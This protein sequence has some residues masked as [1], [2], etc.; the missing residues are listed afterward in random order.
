M[1]RKSKYHHFRR[2]RAQRYN[3]VAISRKKK[4]THS[5]LDVNRNPIFL[6][7]IF[8]ACLTI[9]FVLMPQVVIK[10]FLQVFFDLIIY[11]YLLIVNVLS[12]VRDEVSSQIASMTF[13]DL[14]FEPPALYLPNKESFIYTAY[15]VF[16]I[17]NPI[18][19]LNLL[20]E[21]LKYLHFYSYLYFVYTSEILIRFLI[22]INPL[23]IL[24]T[25]I[26]Y[27]YLGLYFLSGALI[28]V[29]IFINPLPLMKK[30]IEVELYFLYMLLGLF[31]YLSVLLIEIVQTF[32][33]LILNFI[34]GTFEI[35]QNILWFI[36]SSI[37]S[38][39]S[40]I[41][42]KVSLI[43]NFFIFKINKIV[44]LTEPYINYMGETINRTIAGL[45][46]SANDLKNTSASIVEQYNINSPK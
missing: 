23:P 8:T 37:F 14:V 35:I 5:L 26:D 45:M 7:L 34:S 43:F 46:K 15:S 1:P 40:A 38:V 18:P 32:F 41:F 9:L 3:K 13:S 42:N 44:S 2:G 10:D 11:I 17:I 16:D 29:L 4:Q 30:T 6:L 31:I 25:L 19:K 22:F 36:F 24:I 39:F 12:Q 21:Y 27:F 28:K 20:F 33:I